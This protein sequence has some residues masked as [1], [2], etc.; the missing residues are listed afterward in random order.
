MML[1]NRFT[2]LDLLSD[3]SVAALQIS[4]R[5]SAPFAFLFL[6]Q[7]LIWTDVPLEEGNGLPSTCSYTAGVK[8]PNFSCLTLFG[9]Q[10]DRGI[11]RAC[12]SSWNVTCQQGDGCKDD[13]IQNV[14]LRIVRF[15][16]IK[17]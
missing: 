10:R 17:R 6:S 16:F 4:Y 11:D 8:R 9:A 5:D 1:Q 3:L 2:G 14:R 12:T 13:G 7:T 15:H